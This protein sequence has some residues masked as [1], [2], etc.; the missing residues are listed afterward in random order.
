MNKGFVKKYFPIIAGLIPSKLFMA[1]Y[2]VDEHRKEIE[3]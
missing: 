1:M 2:T 3:K